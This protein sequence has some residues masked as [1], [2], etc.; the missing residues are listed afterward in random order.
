MTASGTVA[1]PAVRIRLPQAVAPT[2]FLA[3]PDGSIDVIDTVAVERAVHGE[4]SGWT[5]TDSEIRYAAPFMAG[6]VPYSVICSRLGI[7]A[8]RLKMLLPGIGPAKPS[9]AR[10]RPAKPAPCGTSRGY[11]AHLRRKEPT[12]QPCRDAR[13]ADDR[14]YRLTGTQSQDLE[15]AV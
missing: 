8:A 10:P 2:I 14:R 1:A 7:S 3:H 6:V 12:C 9:M 11:R 15:A 13:A 5:L 4:R